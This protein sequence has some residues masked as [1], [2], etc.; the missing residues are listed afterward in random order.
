MA[1]G[2]VKHNC[3]HAFR[4]KGGDTGKGIVGDAYSGGYPEAAVGVLAGERVLPLLCY[5]LEGDETYYLA[6]GVD[7]GKFLNLVLLEH[8]LYVLAVSL[9]VQ[10]GHQ[11]LAGHCVFYLDV[12]IGLETDVAVGDDSH[13]HIVVVN[14]GDTAYVVLVHKFQ[15]VSHCLALVD[16]DR[17]HNHP[18]LRALYLAYFR[19]LLSYGHI[20]VYH[21]N[22]S[23][24]GKC[25]CHRGLCYGI[26][27]GGY[28]GDVQGYVP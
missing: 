8:L 15:G 10:D 18:V 20:L 5:V 14:H 23:F 9:V 26:H 17:V 6:L 22:T 28:Y 2:A 1:V 25:Y 7:H 21:S 16:G 3:I 11:S 12:H 4:H 27:C 24:P 19:G 13:Q